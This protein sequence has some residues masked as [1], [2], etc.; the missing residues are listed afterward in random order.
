MEKDTILANVAHLTA[1]QL[2]EEIMNGNVT[3]N[4]LKYTGELAVAKRKKLQDLIEELEKEEVKAWDEV[5]N[6]GSIL[7]LTRFISNY[8]S[9]KYLESAREILKKLENENREIESAKQATLLN[10]KNNNNIYRPEELID[11]LEKKMISREDLR[12]IIIDNLKKN[13]NSYF[14]DG[15]VIFL[16]KNI[17][18]KDDLYGLGIPKKVL[19]HLNEPDPKLVLGQTPDSIPKGYTEVYFWGSTG[20]GKTTAL[21]AMLSSA[22]NAGYLDIAVGPGYD[23][24]TR[25]KNIFINSVGILPAATATDKTQY[26]PFTLKRPQDNHPR[27]VSLIEL[28]GEI[29]QCFYHKNASLDLPSQTHQDTFNSLNRFLKGENRKIHFFFIDYNKFNKPDYLGLTQGD[30][31]AAASTYFKNNEIFGRTTDAMYVVV[32]KCDLMPCS[33]KDYVTYARDYLKAASLTAFMNTL[34]NNCQ[35]YS[36]NAGKL[37]IEPFSLGGV[38]FNDICDFDPTYANNLVDILFS[39]I[40][41]SKSIILDFF[42]R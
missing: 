32:T 21:A 28:S 40:P 17:L 6:S 42:N 15:I 37:T 4:E 13:N 11:L 1:E 20:S 35:K 14:K 39:R 30:Y 7:L 19:E 16:N 12:G 3:M 26:L 24:M 41:A 31:L 2:F 27:S 36:I 10:I 5:R 8:P 25:L 33:P 9:G 38:Y 29:F 23:Y 18:S 34:K 22:H